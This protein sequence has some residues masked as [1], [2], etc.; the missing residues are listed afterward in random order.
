MSP[1]A[2]A[3]GSQAGEAGEAADTDDAGTPGWVWA[4]V[5]MLLL[6]A[7]AVGAVYHRRWSNERA[8]NSLF[9]G[10]G[11]QSRSLSIKPGHL[12]AAAADL[13]SGDG[14]GIPVYA[15]PTY[16]V[17][18]GGSALAAGTAVTPVYHVS[19][20]FDENG[21]GG[22]GTGVASPTYHIPMAVVAAD[23][24]YEVPM[25]PGVETGYLEVKAV[26]GQPMYRVLEPG[27]GSIRRT[28][29][30]VASPQLCKAPTVLPG[31]P[32]VVH[33]T[34]APHVYPTRSRASC[35]A[36]PL[37]WRAVMGQLARSRAHATCPIF[38]LP[39][40]RRPFR[41]AR[42]ERRR[43]PAAYLRPDQPRQGPAGV[44]LGQRV[45]DP[46]PPRAAVVGLSVRYR[47]PSARLLKMEKGG[48]TFQ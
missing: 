31:R 29:S 17:P 43:A 3:D 38:L 4:I 26:T 42:C 37:R 14:I 8:L 46:R 47:I 30:A 41:P 24:T 33:S 5:V 11:A 18:L 36:T 27:V 12:A 23:Q 13:D 35:I 1:A 19:C 45:P 20:G 6:G 7:A 48:S 40:R 2:A 22:A 25:E 44:D 32:D 9:Q 28:R 21:N 34:A 39:R 10:G 15:N 16:S